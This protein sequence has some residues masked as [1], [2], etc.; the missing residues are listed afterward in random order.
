MIT[1]PMFIRKFIV[2]FVESAIAAILL[3][4]LIIPASVDEAYKTLAVIGLA[5]FSALVSALRR[6][7]PEFV[8]WFKSK[9]NVG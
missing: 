4:S 7:A 6:A 3:I 5:V 8:G 1:W 2:D 9:L